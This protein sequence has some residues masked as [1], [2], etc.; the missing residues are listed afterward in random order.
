MTETAAEPQSQA[1]NTLDGPSTP[2]L[3]VS[4]LPLGGKFP[5][6]PA[7]PFWA[8]A[9]GLPDPT[10]VGRTLLQ[11]TGRAI[12]GTPAYAGLSTQ[13]TIDGQALAAYEFLYG[14]PNEV[15][16]APTAP[17]MLNLDSPDDFTLSWTTYEDVYSDSQGLK[18]PFADT[19]TDKDVATRMFWR[20]I[21]WFGI[22]YN[23]LVVSKITAAQAPGVATEFGQAWTDNNMD[24]Q[25]AAGLAYEIDTSIL[26][27][28]EPTYGPDGAVRFTPGTRILLTQDPQSKDL[29]PV[30]IALLTNDGKTRIYQYSDNNWIYALQAAKTSITVWGIWV[31]HVGH[32][33]V[34]TAAMQM[35][36]YNSLPPTHPLWLLLQH[37]S[38]SLIDFDYMLFSFLW[39]KISPPTPVSGYEQ[40]LGLLDQFLAPPRAFLDDDPQNELAKAGIESGDFTV[41]S[42]WD[43]YP[44]AGYLLTLSKISYAFVKVVVDEIYKQDGDV[45]NDPGLQAWLTA[46][47]DPSVG[48][49][50]LPAQ[51]HTK[52]ALKELLT[53]LLYRVT[54]HAAGSISPVVN[55]TLAFVSNFPPCLQSAD[56]PE[57]GSAGLTTEQLLAVMPHTGTIGGMTTFYFTF[58][59]SDPVLPAIPKGGLNLDLYWP[60]SQQ[61]LNDA[62]LAYRKG[63][64]DF[65]DIYVKEWNAELARI[66]GILAGPIPQYATG[67]YEQWPRSIEI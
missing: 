39:G 34:G 61:K 41:K 1:T 9:D 4:Q 26:Q 65:V 35:T 27:S 6:V 7:V 12:E 56:V 58:A 8:D 59:Y 15:V 24:A 32:W 52:A 2:S 33:H 37:Q 51:I 54:A 46:S 38:Q 20:T 45:R 62:L 40:L 16:A 64:R 42:T 21:A 29:T 18:G 13:Y 23:L 44:V 36:M 31:G 14:T 28:L 5:N 11:L 66:Q 67:Q 47:R 49:V 48:N 53:S 43:A 30:A 17:T 3:Y 25:G 19:L 55:P 63:I 10:H 50:R 57:P 60:P 22:P